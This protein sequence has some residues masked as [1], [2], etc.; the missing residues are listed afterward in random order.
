MPLE[1]L[2]DIDAEKKRLSKELGKAEAELVKV[3]N[4]LANEQFVSRA[5]EAVIEE[6]RERQ[7]HWKDRAAELQQMLDNLN[8]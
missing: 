6:N 4:K 5:P 2:I 7:Q 8:G 3:N 1:G